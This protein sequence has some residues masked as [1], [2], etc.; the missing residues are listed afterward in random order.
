MNN[1]K[2]NTNTVDAETAWKPASD[3]T[4]AA[5]PVAI[6]GEASKQATIATPK[7]LRPLT[8]KQ[9]AFVQHLIDNPKASAAEAARHAYNGTTA[10][11][12]RQQATENM[13]K[14]GI[15]L[16]LAKH[17]RTAESTLVKVMDYSRK[18]G[19]TGTREGASYAQVAVG[20]AKDILDRVHG[21]ATQRTETANVSVVLSI[22][23]TDT[24]G[25]EQTENK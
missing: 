10:R 22:D 12:A 3:G 8:R 6:K 18:Y 20:A 5:Q 25:Q 19:E 17:S 21:K 13:A 15:Q 9:Q 14:P 23:L 11:S 1:V 24:A 2:Q 16:E 7:P 4:P